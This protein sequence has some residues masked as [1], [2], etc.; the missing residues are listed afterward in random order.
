MVRLKHCPQPGPVPIATSLKSAQFPS[1]REIRTGSVGSL[2]KSGRR[3]EGRIRRA[4]TAVPSDF[5]QFQIF[6]LSWEF[7]RSI[8]FAARGDD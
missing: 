2:R 5:Y 3:I 1:K 4:S 6:P 8:R 7:L